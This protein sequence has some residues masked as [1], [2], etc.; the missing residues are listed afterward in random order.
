MSHAP[1]GFRCALVEVSQS[2]WFQ[3]SSHSCQKKEVPAA[4]REALP[5]SVGEIRVSRSHPANAI[6]GDYSSSPVL[7]SS[8]PQ[9]ST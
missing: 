6:D 2:L 3:R 9:I 1:E 5:R 8:L 7:G 4:F